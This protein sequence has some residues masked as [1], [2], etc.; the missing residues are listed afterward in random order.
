MVGSLPLRG[1]S[2]GFDCRP[3]DAQITEGFVF[4][5][6]EALPSMV[7]GT[8]RYYA[9]LSRPLTAIPHVKIRLRIECQRLID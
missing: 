8:I 2:S 9:E 5:S 6:K 7:K 1:P 4:K 3:L